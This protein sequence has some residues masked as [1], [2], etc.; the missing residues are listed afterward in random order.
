MPGQLKLE[1]ITTANGS[2]LRQ[3]E[4]QYNNLVQTVAAMQ[5]GMTGNQVLTWYGVGPNSGTA[6]LARASTDT[7]VG[8]AAC[9]FTIL[10]VP[11]VKAVSDAGT[12]FAGS[13]TIPAST[14]GVIGI[15]VIANGTVSYVEGAANYTTGYSTEALAIAALPPQITV[16]ARMGYLTIKA[17]ASGWVQAT[18]ALAGGSSGNPATTT[19]YYPNA[20]VCTPTGLQ[21]GPNGSAAGQVAYLPSALGLSSTGNA[22]TNGKNGVIVGAGLAIGSTDTRVSNT[23]FIYNANGLTNIPKAAVAAGTALGALGTVPAATWG[24]LA[25]IIDGAGTISYLSGPSNY[26]TGYK[27]EQAALGD[28]NK[29]VVTDG[30][31]LMGVVT[32]QAQSGNA[33][34]AG[35]DAFAG[36]STGNEAAATNYYSTP[37]FTLGT[38]VTASLIADRTATVLSSSQY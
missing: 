13:G 11:V 27:N 35:T 8:T 21:Y 24:I 25:V 9:L 1:K 6:P 10:G 18:D 14:W 32:V 12:A 19:N 3:L 31:C 15:D 26:T 16:K 29:I 30:S 34:I 36:G 28:M 2:D 22:W 20:G 33:W 37:G 7:R 4:I 23:A 5:S 38:G 17:S